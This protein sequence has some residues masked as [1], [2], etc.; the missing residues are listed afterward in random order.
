MTTQILFGVVIV[1]AVIGLT[2]VVKDVGVPSRFAPVAAV[3]FGILAGL[4]QLYAGQWQWIQAVVVGVAMGLSAVGLYSGVTSA[5]SSYVAPA[6][7]GQG[8]A[9]S[10]PPLA[11]KSIA[12]STASPVA[13]EPTPKEDK[14]NSHQPPA[15]NQ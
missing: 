13:P 3:L 8:S 5:L 2:Q 15:T 11:S 14:A 6:F 10:S 1:P 7:S 4:A 9:V 12:V